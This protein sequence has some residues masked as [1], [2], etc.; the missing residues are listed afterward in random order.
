MKLLL[1]ICCAPCAIVPVREL[2]SAGTAVT[3]F[4]FRHNIHP[5]SSA[6]AASKPLTTMPAKSAW[7]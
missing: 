6:C 2:R 4:F 7:R 1:H 3:G 5:F